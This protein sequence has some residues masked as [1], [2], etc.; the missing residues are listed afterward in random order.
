MTTLLWDSSALAKRY[1]PERGSNLVDYLFDESSNSRMVAS[2]V[3]YAEVRSVLR[4]ALNRNSINA[5]AYGGAIDTLADD[6]LLTP[7][8]SLLST[9]D[10]AFLGGVAHI[11]HHNINASDASIL[12]SYL[13]FVSSN[14]T[15]NHCFVSSD[16]NFLRA[17]RS[18]SVTVIDPEQ[19][20]VHELLALKL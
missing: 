6:W 13:D 12:H 4:R 15:R 9:S 10:S 11:D 16:K 20:T 18:T 3:V 8:F 17:A 1:V 5:E 2:V 7:E 14:T 19:I